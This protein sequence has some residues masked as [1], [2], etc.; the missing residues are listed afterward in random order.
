M[1]PL[2]GE[3]NM[4]AAIPKLP[5]LSESELALLPLLD[6]SEHADGS[7]EFHDENVIFRPLSSLED[8]GGSSQAIRLLYE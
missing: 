7:I 8:D 3:L 6:V 5:I 2:E 1:A 4:S